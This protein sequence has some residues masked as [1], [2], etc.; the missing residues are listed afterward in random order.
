[1]HV[2]AAMSESELSP[3]V[4][5]AMSESSLRVESPMSESSPSVATMIPV[6]F[7]CVATTMPVSSPCVTIPAQQTLTACSVESEKKRRKSWTREFKI[8]VIEFYRENNLCKPSKFFL[9][10]IKTVL[11]WVRDEYTQSKER[12]QVQRS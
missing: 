5:T 10:N 4:A 12:K 8:L 2:A 9:L 11:R 3:C 1:M 6:S 7:P